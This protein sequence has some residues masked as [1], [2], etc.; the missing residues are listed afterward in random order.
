MPYNDYAFGLEALNSRSRGS[1]YPQWGGRWS[2]Y[3]AYSQL[4]SLFQTFSYSGVLNTAYRPDLKTGQKGIG[5]GD[6]SYQVSGLLYDPWSQY[7]GIDPRTGGQGPGGVR[8]WADQ[9]FISYDTPS[10]AP[11]DRAVTQRFPSDDGGY[12]TTA[13]TDDGGYK[14]IGHRTTA[15]NEDGY[16]HP[17]PYLPQGGVVSAASSTHTPLYEYEKQMAE[18]YYFQQGE[19]YHNV[20][21][22]T[23]KTRIKDAPPPPPPPAPAPAPPPRRRRRRSPIILDL[24][25]NRKLDVTGP[26]NT[27]EVANIKNTVTNK[28]VTNPDKSVDRI[29]TTR[30][31]SDTLVNWGTDDGKE[32][33]KTFFD[34]DGDGQ[35]NR[36]EWLKKGTNDGL[37]VIDDG[38]GNIKSGKQIFGETGLNGEKS[39][40]KNGWEKLRDLYDKDKNGVV[41]G[42]ELSNLKVWIDKNGDAKTDAGELKT[43]QELGIVSIDLPKDGSL[44]G[45]FTKRKEIGYIDTYHYESTTRVI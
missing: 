4:L 14:D 37:L 22:D 19:Q 29:S 38:T 30:H 28:E 35:P 36:T 23:V 8:T 43:L 24:D 16:A 6:T 26:T 25:G 42:A 39:K 17:R 40:Y 41:E 20:K 15:I 12:A 3:D 21:E 27:T 9:S 11:V 31:E 33:S 7:R 32:G 18:D 2:Q 45:S 1:N 13:I 5:W 44:V 34:L 10:R